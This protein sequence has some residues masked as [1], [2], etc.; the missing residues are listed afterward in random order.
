VSSLSSSLLSSSSISP[1]LIPSSSISPPF[2]PS[3]SPSSAIPPPVTPSSSISAP[4]IPSSSST[5]SS[6]ISPAST[7]V[8]QHHSSTSNI[9]KTNVKKSLTIIEN[10]EYREYAIFFIKINQCFFYLDKKKHKRS[11]NWTEEETIFFINLWSEYYDKLMAGGSRNMPIYHSIAEQFN[12]LPSGRIMSGQEVK[13]K[14]TNLVAEY[15]KKKKEQGR[16]GG[17]PSS[18]PYFDQ[19][20]KLLGKK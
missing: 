1:P 12:Q 6:S 8:K 13:S 10:E 7:S 20:D 5:L 18:W 16:T 19:I 9:N 17:S 15:R 4:L 3:P 14:I 11:K 2:V